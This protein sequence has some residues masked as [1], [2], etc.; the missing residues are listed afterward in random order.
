[1]DKTIEQVA[2]TLEA[3]RAQGQVGFYILLVGLIIVVVLGAGAFAYQ[4]TVISKFEASEKI[5]ASLL[6][7]IESQIKAVETEMKGRELGLK[8]RE[9]LRKIFSEQFSVVR[10]TN[11]ELRTE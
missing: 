8:E 3:L 10:D 7:G 6:K 11:A 5:T 4:R 2:L 1:M 9:D